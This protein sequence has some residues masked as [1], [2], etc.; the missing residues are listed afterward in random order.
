MT[1]EKCNGFLVYPPKECYE[2]DFTEGR[3][4]FDEK[5]I[6]EVM[7]R[8]KDSYSVHFWNFMTKGIQLTKNSKS[9]YIELKILSSRFGSCR[10]Q[11]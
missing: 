1:R 5:D 3:K 11:I 10:R 4:F 9:A 7:N 2:I 8:T 6:D